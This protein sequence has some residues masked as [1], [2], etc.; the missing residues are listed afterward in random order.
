MTGILISIDLGT[1]RLKVAAFSVDGTLHEQRHRRHREHGRG[2]T[3]WQDPDA[4]WQDTVD[5]VREVRSLVE[6]RLG[7]VDALGLS[8]SGRGGAA[9][10]ADADGNVLI[11]PWSDERH[12]G[13]Q[14]RLR[15]HYRDALAPYA[16]ALLAK[17]VWLRAEA[18]DVFRRARYAFY[19]KDFLLYRLT[20]V[21][22]T[23]WSSG[24]DGPRWPAGVLAELGLTESL[25]PRPALPWQIAGHLT[26][27]AARCLDLP[28]GTPVAVGAHDGVC[29]NIGA[30]A[31]RPGD[32]AITLGTHAVVRAVAEQT[33]PGARRFYCLPETRQVVGGNALMGGRATDWFL[34]LLG[35]SETSRETAFA[36]LEAAARGVAPGAGGV[37][38][39]P[40]LGGQVAPERRTAARATWAGL[41]IEHGRDE[42][43]RSV[44]E[45]VAFAVEGVFGQVLGWCG[46]PRRIRVTGG[47]ARSDLWV[48]ILA[49]VLG[50]PLELADAAAEGR[51]AA[52][53]LAVGLGRFDDLDAAADALVQLDRRVEPA[54]ELSAAYRRLGADWKR[55][56]DAVRGYEPSFDG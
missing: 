53:L 40:Y 27:E 17:C 30:G 15:R 13:E 23:D 43:Y 35:A 22:C 32:Y 5:L 33:A 56:D 52:M 10:F 14:A 25:L 28:E 50:R 1:T 26:P 42:A 12:A 46:E 41:S 34:D 47:G 37:R 45:G 38:F 7:L 51:G 49:A 39:L 3:R 19:A 8:L 2:G 29:A 36:E 48:D 4:W 20:G 16:A 18:P 21:H 31:C 24:P 54:P 9:I 44:L 6:V 11:P 55:L